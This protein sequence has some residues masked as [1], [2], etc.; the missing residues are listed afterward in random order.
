MVLSLVLILLDLEEGV[1]N[2]NEYINC[3]IQK[4]FSYELQLLI[5]GVLYKELL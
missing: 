3:S 1:M 5:V 2:Y 4:Y